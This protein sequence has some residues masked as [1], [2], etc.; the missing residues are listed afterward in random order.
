MKTISFVPFAV[1][2]FVL[3]ISTQAVGAQLISGAG[4]SFPYPLYSKWFSDSDD[5]FLWLGSRFVVHP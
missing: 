5:V 2:T 4:A 1:Y 3:L